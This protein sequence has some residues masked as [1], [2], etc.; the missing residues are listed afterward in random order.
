MHKLGSAVHLI[1]EGVTVHISGLGSWTTSTPLYPRSAHR[2]PAEYERHSVVRL[3][4][5]LHSIL[6]ASVSARLTC[7]AMGA[8]GSLSGSGT[9]PDTPRQIPGL[10][11][12][13]ILSAY[14]VE[15]SKRR[16]SM[17]L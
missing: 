10:D 7:S 14:A 17:G 5:A 15:I 6:C 3:E 11:R 13:H 8:M 4:D 9:Y 1:L 2:A 16:K 12:K